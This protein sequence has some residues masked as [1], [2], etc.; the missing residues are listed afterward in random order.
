[1]S[2]AW[3]AAKFLEAPSPLDTP[4]DIAQRRRRYIEWREACIP[5]ALL[6]VLLHRRET[7]QRAVGGGS[8]AAAITRSGPS[9]A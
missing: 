8:H 5:T 1:M 3:A 4:E 7:S 6:A 2:R 9:P